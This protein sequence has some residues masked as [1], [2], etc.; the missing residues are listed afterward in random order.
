MYV[1]YQC[2]IIFSRLQAFHKSLFKLFKSEHTESLGLEKV[3]KFIN[4]EN[5]GA[6]FSDAEIQL[7]LDHMADQN[8]L[9]ISDN[10]V[11]LI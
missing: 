9:M 1:V 10:T 7:A 3:T 8:K 5:A 6:E 11:F 2:V 4:E